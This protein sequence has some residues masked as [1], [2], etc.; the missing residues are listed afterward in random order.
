M[1][2]ASVIRPG[3]LVSLKS[4]LQGG[5]VYERV[6]INTG[7]K[8]PDGAEVS[9]WKTKRT[10][11]D[12]VEH[13]AATKARGAARSLIV[14]CCSTTSFGLLCP[15]EQEG[16]LDAAVKAARQVV[17][18]FND[19]A[20]HTRIG[21]FVIKGKVASTDAEA[22]RAITQEI[23]ELTIAMDAGIKAFD[24]DAI[25]KAASRARELSSMLSEEK[26]G[27]INGAI[28]QARKAARTIVKRI[29]TEGE[30]RSVVMMDI[31]RGQI[32][33][34]RIAFLDMSGDSDVVGGELP[35]VQ[36]QRFADLDVSDVETTAPS[37]NRQMRQMEMEVE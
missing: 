1:S 32:E 29:E 13:T 4:T 19:S 9:E 14:K 21:I 10:I 36:Q 23:A 16:A 20:K 27:K 31:Q 37:K 3:L 12:P 34:A 26:Q 30:D 8:L 7:E 33:S 5:V 28:E 6:D 11:E 2:N 25:R 15:E 18:N 17:D 22:A 35:S 24:P